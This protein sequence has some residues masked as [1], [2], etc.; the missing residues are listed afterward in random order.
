MYLTGLIRYKVLLPKYIC[1]CALINSQ[2]TRDI[3][4]VN[5]PAKA[6]EANVQDK[7]IDIDQSDVHM[8]CCNFQCFLTFYSSSPQLIDMEIKFSSWVCFVSYEFPKFYPP[9]AQYT[10]QECNPRKNPI[11]C[12]LWIYFMCCFHGLWR[13]RVALCMLVDT[14]NRVKGWSKTKTCT[15][16]WSYIIRHQ[17]LTKLAKR[18]CFVASRIPTTS[19]CRVIHR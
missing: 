11:F 9:C 13:P 16:R 17:E 3:F 1:S 18:A 4:I 6:F 2:G 8:L 10:G 14:N 19:S 12:C 5:H 15:I 7:G